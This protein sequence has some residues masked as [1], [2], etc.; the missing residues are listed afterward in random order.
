MDGVPYDPRVE[1][2]RLGV[3][4]SRRALGEESAASA[5]KYAEELGYTVFWLGGSPRLPMLR[6]CLEATD[7]LVVATSIVNV[8]TYEPE[9]LAGEYAALLVDFPERVLVGL[10][11][12]HPEI[13]DAYTRPLSSMRRFLDALDSTEP[14]L[15]ADRRCLGALA[16][17]MVALSGERSLGA[18][19][20]FVPA[21]HTAAARGRLVSGALLAPEVAFVLDEDVCSA[22]ATARE[23]ARVY[24]DLSNYA[25]NLIRHGFNEQDL[26][27]G[28]SN[29]LIDTV[30]PHGSPPEI[31]ASLQA[32]FAAGANHVAVQALGEPGIPRRSWTGAAEAILG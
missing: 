17:G 7:R 1:L 6:P 19:P 15:P 29:R 21:T 31:A 22:R 8:W 3:W 10:G 13:A 18:I 14:P 24:L 2:G 28:G 20:Y 11:I 12:G 5:A 27:R 32:H 4:I 23:Y 25:T 9:K 16:P 26:A 30:V